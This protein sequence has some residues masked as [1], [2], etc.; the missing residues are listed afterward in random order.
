MLLLSDLLGN[1]LLAKKNKLQHLAVGTFIVTGLGSYTSNIS[2]ADEVFSMKE[3]HV[4]QPCYW[5]S[6]VIPAEGLCGEKMRPD[7]SVLIQEAGKGNSIAAMRLGQ[8]YT[9]GAWGIKKDP[10]KAVKWYIRAAELGDRYSQLRLANAYEF[11]RLGV[12]V[13]NALAIR[14]YKMAT[15]YGIH[16]DLEERIENLEKELSN[17]K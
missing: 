4:M 2:A 1:S 17:T 6:R 3:I 12:R 5:L 16:L 8:L 7:T 13:N 9:S 14:Y 10:V 15:E 11:G